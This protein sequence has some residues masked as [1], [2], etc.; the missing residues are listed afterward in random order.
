MLSITFFTFHAHFGPK[1]YFWTRSH[2]KQTTRQKNHLKSKMD[3]KLKIKNFYN[4]LNKEGT[5][6][7]QSMINF[8]FG[9]IHLNELHLVYCIVKSLSDPFWLNE[10]TLSQ[11]KGLIRKENEAW[12]AK[13]SFVRWFNSFKLTDLCGLALSYAVWFTVWTVQFIM[14]RFLPV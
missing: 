12:A 1:L 5:V 8:Q 2:Q 6:L 11:S 10:L 14:L 7:N 4:V 9:R 13:I 3:Q